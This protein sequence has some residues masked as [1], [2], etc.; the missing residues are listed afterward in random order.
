MKPLVSIIMLSFNNVQ[1]VKAAIES[2]LKQTYDHWELVISDD[3]SSDG[4]WELIQKLSERDERIKIYQPSDNL[5]IVK[6]RLFAFTKTIGEL[7]CHLDGDDELY[8]YSLET[9]VDYLKPDIALAQSDNSWINDQG[10]V[11]QYH[12]NKEPD[13]N[14][15]TAGWRHFGMYWRWAYDQTNGYNEKLSNACEDG[16]LFMQIAEKYPYIRVPYVLYKHRWHS[17]NMSF[18][19]K[20]CDVCTERP[21]CNYIRVWGKHAG[22]DPISF[23]RIEDGP[24]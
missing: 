10:V 2:V 24:V 11:Y 22:V 23:K 17:R 6:N 13:G 8:P 19:T 18:K 16:D 20:K 4:S 14:L 15:S 7:V 3:L 9:M 1:F 12:A 5:G 21:V